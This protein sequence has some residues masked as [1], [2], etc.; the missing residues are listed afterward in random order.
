MQYNEGLMFEWS[1]AIKLGLFHTLSILFSKIFYRIQTYLSRDRCAKINQQLLL[2]AQS[3]YTYSTIARAKKGRFQVIEIGTLYGL[4]TWSCVVVGSFSVFV[5][6]NKFYFEEKR[7]AI[8]VH[9]QS[10]HLIYIFIDCCPYF[11]IYIYELSSDAKF[12]NLRHRFV[13]LIATR[14]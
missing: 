6:Q 1:V 9:V 5:R 2:F 14:V 11:D 3:I 12:C 8:D 13:V 10:S 7:S 4:N